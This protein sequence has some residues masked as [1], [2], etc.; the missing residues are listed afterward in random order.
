[1]Q[2]LEKA[3]LELIP[4]RKSYRAPSRMIPS[5]I[6]SV[7][8]KTLG[9][10]LN[11]SET[12]AIQA[13]FLERGYELKSFGETADLT[14]INTCTVTN[15]ADSGSRAAIRQAIRVSPQGRIAV[16]G[17]YAQVSP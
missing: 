7:A 11:Q 3:I 2:V 10:K 9:C 13:K 17:C 12:D 6:K 5:P 4:S 14:V 16:T 15:D 1:M 8:F